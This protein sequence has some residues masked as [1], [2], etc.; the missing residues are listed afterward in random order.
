MLHISHPFLAREATYI[1]FEWRPKTHRMPPKVELMPETSTMLGISSDDLILNLFTHMGRHT[2]TVLVKFVQRG[3]PHS[4]AIDANPKQSVKFYCLYS[5]YWL[6]DAHN[7]ALL[8]K[9]DWLM[10]PGIWSESIWLCQRS[11]SLQ[12]QAFQELWNAAKLSK[13]DTRWPREPLYTAKL[14]ESH[15]KTTV[16]RKEIRMIPWVWTYNLRSMSMLV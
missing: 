10:N 4:T 3:I 6:K 16:E 11:A 15:R 12:A 8:Q 5:T 7:Q 13:W 9:P 2:L 1:D 14:F